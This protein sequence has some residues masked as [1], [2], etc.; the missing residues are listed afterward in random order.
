[1]ENRNLAIGLT[2]G[3][4]LL[5]GLP[6]LGSICISIL[7]AAGGP[8]A[9]LPGS[10]WLLAFMLLCGGIFLVAIPVV[11]GVFTLRRKKSSVPSLPADEPI[12]PPN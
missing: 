6:G 9:D 8:I 10:E 5:C 3:A 11:V 7:V 2:I 1:M 4:V 12:P